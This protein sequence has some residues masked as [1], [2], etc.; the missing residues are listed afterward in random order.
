MHGGCGAL[1]PQIVCKAHKN[2][3]QF[4]SQKEFDE[5]MRVCNTCSG[6]VPGTWKCVECKARKEK[7]SFSKWLSQRK[8]KRCRPTARCNQCMGAQERDQARVRS[9]NLEHLQVAKK[10]KM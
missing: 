8:D 1:A 6:R 3:N 4:A 5:E 10:G 7:Q 9:S 2:K